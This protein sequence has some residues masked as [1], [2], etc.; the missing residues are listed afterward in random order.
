M[1]ILYYFKMIPVKSLSIMIFI[2]SLILSFLA[3]EISGIL[4]PYNGSFYLFSLPFIIL[5]NLVL[6]TSL[7]N[8]IIKSYHIYY[9]IIIAFISLKVP[10]HYSFLKWPDG[11][12][13]P[14]LAWS[15]CIDF[16]CTIFSLI[17]ILCMV[18]SLVRIPKKK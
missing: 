9:L 6:I 2:F 1:K 7:V 13:G 11:D 14:G 8:I 10:S 16:G 18:L 3:L 15:F 17:A 4:P 12:D 5:V